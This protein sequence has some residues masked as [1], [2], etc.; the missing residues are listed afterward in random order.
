[1]DYFSIVGHICLW[2]KDHQM[3]FKRITYHLT[4]KSCACCMATFSSYI[5]FYKVNNKS[6]G[7][8]K[9]QG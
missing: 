8:L 2:D 4:S 1:M 9:L 6:K 3:N 7:F 5:L